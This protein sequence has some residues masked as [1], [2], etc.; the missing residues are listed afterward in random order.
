MP[1][2]SL[3]EKTM[4]ESIDGTDHVPKHEADALAQS[5]LLLHLDAKIGVP[6]AVDGR[7]CQGR[8]TENERVH[9]KLPFVIQVLP[10]HPTRTSQK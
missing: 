8:V 7:D 10:V 3:R 5:T 4:G 2:D 6:D 1:L 9:G